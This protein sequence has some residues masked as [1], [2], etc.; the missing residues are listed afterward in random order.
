[1]S[2]IL[3]NI[4]LSNFSSYKIGGPAK[5]FAE[6]ESTDD[7][8]S[9][10]KQWREISKDSK[11]NGKDL[12]RQGGIFVLGG[13]TNVLVNDNGYDG[14]VILNKIR[15]IRVEDSRITVGSGVFIEDLLNFCIEFP[16]YLH[17][18]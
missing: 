15:H 16:S 18:D 4:A 17:F 12:S 9:V 13:G 7:M 8:I 10:L 2:K 11:E 3:N 6:V 14:L 1:M 5:Y